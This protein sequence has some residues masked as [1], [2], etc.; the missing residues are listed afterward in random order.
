MAAEATRMTR[1]RRESKPVKVVSSILVGIAV[2]AVYIFLY[3][4]MI[5]TA[6]FSVNDAKI[7]T[8]PYSGFTTRWYSELFADE[9]MVNAILYSLRVAVTA[10]FIAACAAM[11]LALIVHRMRVRGGAVI[12]ALGWC[13]E[14]PSSSSSTRRRSNRAFGRSSPAT[15]RSSRR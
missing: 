15:S 10:V 7:Q 5:I 14:S 3:S 11:I 8:L 2:L 12:Q 13:S 6:L 4:P 9:K 1:R